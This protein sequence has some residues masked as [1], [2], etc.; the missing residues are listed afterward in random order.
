MD[1]SENDVVLGNIG[2][3]KESH[4]K[5]VRSKANLLNEK[6]N[7]KKILVQLKTIA[8]KDIQEKGSLLPVLPSLSKL[9]LNP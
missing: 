5:L 7:L 4:Q 2:Q 3:V 8:S 6:E 9:S 1:K